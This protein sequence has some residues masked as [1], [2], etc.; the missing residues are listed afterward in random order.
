MLSCVRKSVTKCS[1]WPWTV[2]RCVCNG[3]TPTGS[4]G[5][6]SPVRTLLGLCL[7]VDHRPVSER[8]YC[9]QLCPTHTAFPCYFDDKTPGVS[10]DQVSLHVPNTGGVIWLEILVLHNQPQ[11]V[12]FH[13]C[14]QKQEAQWS[15]CEVCEPGRREFQYSFW[16]NAGHWGTLSVQM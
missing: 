11:V 2:T 14:Q 12:Y 13:R 6:C 1:F 16:D 10:T 8:L 4:Y 3:F 15:H 7:C 9:R 5:E